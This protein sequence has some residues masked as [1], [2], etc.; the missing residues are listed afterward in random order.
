MIHASG[1]AISPASRP[2]TANSARSWP[3]SLCGTSSLSPDGPHLKVCR[4][5]QHLYNPQHFIALIC[6]I[7]SCSV[8]VKDGNV[9]HKG[10]IALHHNIPNTALCA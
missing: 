8:K 3:K 1:Q 9:L 2:D 10:I 4:P 6:N 5:V 7:D